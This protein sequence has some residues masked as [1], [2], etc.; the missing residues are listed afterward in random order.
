MLIVFKSKPENMHHFAI[1]MQNMPFMVGYQNDDSTWTNV[2][3]ENTDLVLDHEVDEDKFQDRLD[4]FHN[5]VGEIYVITDE[6]T[7]DLF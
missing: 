3:G 2:L 5:K 6:E 1:F 7:S 4:H